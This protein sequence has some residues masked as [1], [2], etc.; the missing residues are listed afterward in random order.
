[1]SLLIEYEKLLISKGL[2]KNT[3]EIYMRCAQL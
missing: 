3:I 1:M 2:S